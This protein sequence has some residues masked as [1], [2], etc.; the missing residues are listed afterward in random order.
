MLMLM[1]VSISMTNPVGRQGAISPCPIIS[2]V[3]FVDLYAS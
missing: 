3:P 1:S 2:R